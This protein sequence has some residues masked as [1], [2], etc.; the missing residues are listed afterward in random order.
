MIASNRF[1]EACIQVQKEYSGKLFKLD[2]KKYNPRLSIYL[3][4]ERIAEKYFQHW[5]VGRRTYF[6][7]EIIQRISVVLD[8]YVNE[9]TSGYSGDT[10]PPEI[11]G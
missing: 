4:F 5:Q 2:G 9:L 6:P 11:E 3:R 7:A 1:K 10:D 8:V